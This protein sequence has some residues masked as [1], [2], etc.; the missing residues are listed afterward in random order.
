MKRKCIAFL[1]S[2]IMTSSFTASTVFASERTDD[3]IYDGVKS[4]VN[5]VYVDLNVNDKDKLIE[6]LYQEK[7]SYQESEPVS[8]NVRAAEEKM[9]NDDI[10]RIDKEENYIVD[11][12]NSC[13]QNTG[14]SDWKFNLKYLEENYDSIKEI[15]D[16]NLD[17][18]NSYIEAYKLVKTNESKPSEKVSH[19][20]TRSSSYDAWD[21]VCYANNHATNYNRDY[22]NWGISG[23]GGDCA[24]FVSQCLYAGGKNMRGSN[25]SDFSCW[26]S[27]GTANST[28]QVSSTWRGADAFRNYWQDHATS[29][30]KFTSVSS[31]S[32]DYGYK[33]D[34][35][36]LLNKNGRAVHTMIIV[37]SNNN[38]DFTL[39][40]HSGDTNDASLDYKMTNGNYGGFI[41][42]NLR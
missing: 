13:G 35:V 24:N 4:Y 8:F 2:V 36:S 31:K 11:L 40:A 20:L 25:A 10:E 6:D 1:L 14:L 18:V 26:F 5:E 32:W 22:P 3:K 39:A 12:I 41:I 33:G 28:S 38:P 34:A 16:V 27:Y 7:I 21:A 15:E 42:Y 30:K 23:Y 37:G 17:Y 29:Y 19:V 9:L